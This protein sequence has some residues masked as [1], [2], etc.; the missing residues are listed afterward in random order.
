[1]YSD[2]TT[3]TGKGIKAFTYIVHGQQKAEGFTVR[4]GINTLLEV[5]KANMELVEIAKQA[6]TT[7]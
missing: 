7:L 3:M 1:M 2:G 5:S 4:E 6:K